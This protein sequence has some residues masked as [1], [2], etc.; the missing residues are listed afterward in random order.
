MALDWFPWAEEYLKFASL[1]EVRT[2]L[3]EQFNTLDP[4][5]EYQRL[6]N[7]VQIDSMFTYC[8]EF[9]RLVVHLPGLP[10]SLLEEVY[11]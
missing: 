3:D 9:K 7:I 1:Q 8:S 2:G 10:P 11:T 6:L 5:L 4:D